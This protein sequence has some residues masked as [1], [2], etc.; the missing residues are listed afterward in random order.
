[1]TQKTDDLR[2]EKTM[3]LLPPIAL[4]ERFPISD[5]ASETV[6]ACRKAIHNLL[7][8]DDDRILVVVGPCSIH[9]VDAAMD[10]ANRLV[11][12]RKKYSGELEI[13]MR[14]YF[15]KPRTTVGWKGLVNDPDMDGSFKINDGF[16]LQEIYSVK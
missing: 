9:D 11:E 6:F 14:V 2:I 10:Y 16:A 13:V 1:M 8:G 12:M 15:E 4:I 3:Q 7:H 5:S